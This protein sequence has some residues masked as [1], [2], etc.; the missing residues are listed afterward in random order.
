MGK[1]TAQ[2]KEVYCPKTKLN[3]I[4]HLSPNNNNQ[5]EL[6]NT[7]EQQLTKLYPEVQSDK[8]KD[9]YWYMYVDMIDLVSVLHHKFIF[10]YIVHAHVNIG[11]MLVSCTF[12]TRAYN[13]T[14]CTSN[15]M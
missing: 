12:I 9:N 1:Q 2:A 11:L 13:N 8:R 5:K 14:H 4:P 3:N 7:T 15:Y 10:S 6:K